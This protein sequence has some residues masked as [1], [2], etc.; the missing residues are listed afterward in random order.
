[1]TSWKP[2]YI[3]N[4]TDLSMDVVWPMSFHSVLPVH[5]LAIFRAGFLAAFSSCTVLG[6]ESA[7]FW[8][9][10][11][12]LSSGDQ[13]QKSVASW[14]RMYNKALHMV[15]QLHFSAVLIALLEV[16]DSSGTIGSIAQRDL[17]H[18]AI[19]TPGLLGTAE[20][21]QAPPPK[22]KNFGSHLGGLVSV[23]KE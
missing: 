21:A 9:S 6:A 10:A 17:R 15:W 22:K 4:T 11:I 23:D 5:E 1:M 20:T 18:V 2:P 12:S 16:P 8:P 7:G 13:F 19:T 3:V 14:A